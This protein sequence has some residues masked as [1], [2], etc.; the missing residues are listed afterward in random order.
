MLGKKLKSIIFRKK[1]SPIIEKFTQL[2]DVLKEKPKIDSNEEKLLTTQENDLPSEAEFIY[3]EEIY[4][5]ELKNESEVDNKFLSNQ[6]I[7]D[8]V[9]TIK[10]TELYNSV[11]D[12]PTFL[13]ETTEVNTKPVLLLTWES[14][15]L[16]LTERRKFLQ[17]IREFIFELNQLNT[18]C[19]IIHNHR[20]LSLSSRIGV[21]CWQKEIEVKKFV[22]NAIGEISQ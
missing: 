18:E 9:T 21:K 15:Y 3:E 19:R 8:I 5:W 12:N 11:F 16:N 6:E 7:G 13:I 2:E 4:W 22:E 17:L 10:K 1:E 20:R 14:E